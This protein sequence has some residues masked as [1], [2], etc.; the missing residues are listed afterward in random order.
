MI[1]LSIQLVAGVGERE[2]LGNGL[3]EGKNWIASSR[4]RQ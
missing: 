2:L 3:A 4:A 1:P